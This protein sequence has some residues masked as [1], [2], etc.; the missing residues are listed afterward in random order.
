MNP[1]RRPAESRGRYPRHAR[2]NSLIGDHRNP[3]YVWMNLI[4]AASAADEEIPAEAKMAD[5]ALDGL[6]QAELSCWA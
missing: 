2:L 5:D 1:I 4:E 6:L 3:Q